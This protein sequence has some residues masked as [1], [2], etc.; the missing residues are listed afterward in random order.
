M[1]D[2][3]RRERRVAQIGDDRKPGGQIEGIQR[4]EGE[5]RLAAVGHGERA[6]DRNACDR[7][8]KTHN[9]AVADPLGSRPDGD[10]GSEHL[11]DE[12][13]RERV[14]VGVAIG[15]CYH[16]AIDARGSRIQTQRKGSR[17]AWPERRQSDVRNEREPGGQRGGVQR[18][19]RQARVAGIADCYRAR[20]GDC[21]GRV[22]KSR[23]APDDRPLPASSTAISGALTLAVTVKSNGFSSASLLARAIVPPKLPPPARRAAA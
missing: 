17:L 19:Q 22:P 12:R 14:L 9:L 3:P 6:T 15:D 5:R 1:V 21:Q 2:W 4:R 8:A 13:K 18:R 10:L 16:S 11:A 20:D 7:A 23:I